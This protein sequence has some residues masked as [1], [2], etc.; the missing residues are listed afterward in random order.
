MQCRD[1]VG[2]AS[3][4][5]TACHLCGIYASLTNILA[6]AGLDVLVLGSRKVRTF[7]LRNIVELGSLGAGSMC[8]HEEIYLGLSWCL[9]T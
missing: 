8:G 9:Y 3:L 5:I 7:L 1:Q 4:T 2:L 6:S